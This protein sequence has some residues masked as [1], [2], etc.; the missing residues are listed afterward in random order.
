MK[1]INLLDNNYKDVKSY[2]LDNDLEIYNLI[3]DG[4]QQF[5]KNGTDETCIISF[6]PNIEKMYVFRKDTVALMN[7]AIETFLTYEEYEKC[8]ICQK[9]IE[10]YLDN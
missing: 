4:V 9:I 8:S 6:E 7:K 5:I 3:L 2:L 10:K 1:I